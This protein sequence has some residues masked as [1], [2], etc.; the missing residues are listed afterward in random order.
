MKS[1]VDGDYSEK[2]ILKV[3]S[4]FFLNTARGAGTTSILG[5]GGVLR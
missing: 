1:P 3:F 2:G 4:L 5:L